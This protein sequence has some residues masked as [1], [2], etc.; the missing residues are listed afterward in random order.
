MRSSCPPIASTKL[1]RCRQIH[2][3][4]CFSIFETEG[5]LILTIEAIAACAFPT[6]RRG[7]LDPPS[8][9][10]LKRASRRSRRCSGSAAT[11]SSSLRSS[12]HLLLRRGPAVEMPLIAFVPWRADWWSGTGSRIGRCH[13]PA[14]IRAGGRGRF[15]NGTTTALLDHLTHRCEIIEIGH[16][17]WPF[18]SRA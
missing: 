15:F 12:H 2:I 18:K 8:F 5:C 9:N 3:S 17:S 13:R 4:A 10:S 14:L 16:E 11:T 7:A 1:F 6:P